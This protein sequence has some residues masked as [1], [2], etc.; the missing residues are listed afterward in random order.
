MKKTLISG[1]ALLGML[2]AGLALADGTMGG[3]QDH[4]SWGKDGGKKLEMM[5]KKLD[6]TDDQVSKLKELYQGQK[7]ANKSLRERLKA[8]MKSLRDK[9]DAKASDSDLKSVLD[10][11]SQDRQDLQ[12]A[13]QRMADKMRGILTPTQ[14]AKMV[15]AMGDRAKGMKK[16]KGHRHGVDQESDTKGM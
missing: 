6:L 9:V 3:G 10:S 8:D 4:P 12:A 15:L 13:R 16:M 14:Q 11:L 5:Q 1:L 2:G 7:D